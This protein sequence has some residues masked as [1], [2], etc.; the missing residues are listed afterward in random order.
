VVEDIEHTGAVE[1]TKKARTLTGNLQLLR[2]WPELMSPR[3]NPQFSRYL[4]HKVMRLGTPWAVGA[5]MAAPVVGALSPGPLQSLWMALLAAELGLVMTP[6][7]R[8]AM[9]VMLAA[10]ESWWRF[11]SGDYRW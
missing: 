1:R 2:R 8:E 7:G 6:R 4:I 11:A 5:M 10:F 3:Q 9:E